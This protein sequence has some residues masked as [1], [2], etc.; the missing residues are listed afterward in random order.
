MVK[1]IASLTLVALVQSQ[2][3]VEIFFSSHT[4]TSLMTSISTNLRIK[5]NSQIDLRQ[6]EIKS[7]LSI[8]NRKV[9]PAIALDL[10]S[11]L[12][13]ARILKELSKQKQFILVSFSPSDNYD[14]WEFFIHNPLSDHADAIFSLISYFK[15]EKFVVISDLN[16]DP[17]TA[18]TSAEVFK[19]D[20]YNFYFSDEGSQDSADLL[21][22]KAIKP[23]GIKNFIIFNKGEGAT[24]IISSLKSKNLLTQG[25]GVLLASQSVWGLQGSGLVAVIESGLQNSTSYY[26]YEALAVEKFIRQVISFNEFSN[27]AIRELLEKNTVN[28]HPAQKFMLINTLNSTKIPSGSITSGNLTLTR[29]ILFPGN[30]TIPPNSPYTNITV[31][32]ADGVTNPGS[33]NSST[34]YIVKDGARYAFSYLQKIHFLDNFQISITHTDCGAEVYNASFSIQC[35]ARLRRQLG[36]ALISASYPLLCVGNIVSLRA[37][38]V[39]IPHISENGAAG[40]LASQQSYPEFMRIMKDS[41]YNSGAFIALASVFDWKSICVIYQ[42]N[43]WSNLAYEY[44]LNQTKKS[45]I[46]IVNT[47]RVVA[48]PYRHEMYDKHKPLM[49]YLISLKV[50]IFVMFIMIPD[51]FYFIEDFYDAGLRR[52]E[53]IFIFPSR[54]TENLVI[55]KD[56]VQRAK[57]YDLLYG[58]IVV[59][60]ADWVGE[61]GKEVKKGIIANYPGSLTNRCFSF[62]SVMLL[63]SGI[64]FTLNVGE[65]VEDSKILNANLRKQRFVGCSGTVSIENG[66]NERSVIAFGIYNMRWNSTSDSMYDWWVATYDLS[67]EQLITFFDDIIWY[68]NKTSTPSAKIVYADGCPFDKSL[69]QYSEKGSAVLYGVGSGVLL[70]TIIITYYIWKKW[71]R[72]EIKD[73]IEK[74]RIKFDDFLVMGMIYTDFLQYLSMGPDIKKFDNYSYTLANYA[75]LNFGWVTV[76]KSFWIYVASAVVGIFLW[77]YFAI[78]PTFAI[79]NRIIGKIAFINSDR[80]VRMGI[81]LIGN[82]CFLPII[83]VL[84][85]VFQCNEGIGNDLDES[86]VHSDCTVYCWKGTHLTWAAVSIAALL[87]YL[88][89]AVF[90]R[91]FWDHADDMMKIKTRPAY[92]MLKSVFQVAL[93]FMNKALKP[94]DQAL[95]GFI[96]FLALLVFFL[97]CMKKKPYNY[98]RLNLWVLISYLAVLWNVVISSIFW[99]ELYEGNIFLWISSLYIGW[100]ALLVSGLLIQWKY[101]PSLLYGD[102]APDIGIFFRFSL[103]SKISAAEINKSIRERME[104]RISLQEEI[105]PIPVNK[106]KLDEEIRDYDNT[107]RNFLSH[108]EFVLRVQDIS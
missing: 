81:P 104:S 10:T 69:R 98:Q 16:F 85:S 28:H 73:L 70:S 17:M 84:L 20:I 68:N 55:E 102:K 82:A 34:S 76:G 15:W 66:S 86:F 32:M 106:S 64:K 89:L 23:T 11:S 75:A 35:F 72:I 107:N 97:W 99:L 103:G 30:S 2:L 13:F 56:P 42:N 37:L 29:P 5:L 21:I 100:I 45:D 27:I 44:Y 57:L 54:I 19:K 53:A 67:S 101:C 83:S 52:G 71:W 7:S 77:I 96:Y 49:E 63:M 40:V 39:S 3:L 38:N 74:T 59:D 93:V 4:D 105:Q 61:L 90:Y 58:S 46:K 9:N 18:S 92:L 78:I 24:K 95:Y 88:P 60:Q 31:S 26:N 6:T 22:G 108:D 47:E 65:N 33:T 50:R 62:D 87:V 41:R 12:S 43:T 1:V 94:V 14:F 79:Q 48:S 51:E 8:L 91:P 36:I 25:T 80:I